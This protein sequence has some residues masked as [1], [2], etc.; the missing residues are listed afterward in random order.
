MRGKLGT[1][2]GI[3]SWGRIRRRKDFLHFWA[4]CHLLCRTTPVQTQYTQA[5]PA[6]HLAPVA[7]PSPTL[8]LPPESPDL[9]RRSLILRPD[10]LRKGI[11]LGLHTTRASSMRQHPAR[12]ILHIGIVAHI[13]LLGAH[14]VGLQGPRHHPVGLQGAHPFPDMSTRDNRI[15]ATRKQPVHKAEN[16]AGSEMSRGS[17][18]RREA[19]SFVAG[20]RNQSVHTRTAH[21]H[22]HRWKRVRVRG[23]LLPPR[24]PATFLQ[25]RLVHRRLQ[26]SI[27]VF[28]QSQSIAAHQ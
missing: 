21:V 20:R 17:T 15:R 12:R 14:P 8:A 27:L 9:L 3:L 22:D 11:G 7:I 5:Q 1:S 26:K 23:H 6:V 4:R 18:R 10:I 24:P 16:V 28:F 13:G 19:T 2:V 25:A